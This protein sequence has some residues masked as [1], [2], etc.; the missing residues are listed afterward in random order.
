MGMESAERFIWMEDELIC[1]PHKGSTVCSLGVGGW[2]QRMLTQGNGVSWPDPLLPRGSGAPYI[3]F[4]PAW[5][6]PAG[7]HV[8]FEGG[9]N[10]HSRMLFSLAVQ[11]L[12]ALLSSRA[13]P[14]LAISRK[15]LAPRVTT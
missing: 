10:G 6:T 14:P 4:H 5:V 2:G 3:C 1:V 15:P 11:V 12:K 8:F 13:K 9:Q 7:V